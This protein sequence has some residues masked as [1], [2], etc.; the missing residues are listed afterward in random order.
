M[1]AAPEDRLE[2]EPN[3][4]PVPPEGGWTADDLDRIPGLPPHTELIDGSLVF[5]SPQRKFHTRAL[6]LLESAL[7]AHV[8]VDLDVDREMTIRLDTSNRPE[9]DLLVY[10]ADADT[11]PDQTWYAP[12]DVVL[13]VEVVSPDSVE[14]DRG[15]KPR[16]YAE[17]GVKHFW[18]VEQ[19]D[20]DL[21]VVY[22]YELDPATRAYTP[23]G[24]HH[25]KMNLSVPF[26][27]DVDLG[28]LYRRGRR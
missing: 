16:K 28:D 23:T 22:V 1:S 17:A 5:M 25:Q 12:E 27:I 2:Q 19:G 3:R 7:L 18:R 4:W 14:R 26:P 13:V 20:D 10:R 9:P 8:P 6:W 11:G 21:P 15:V 24:I